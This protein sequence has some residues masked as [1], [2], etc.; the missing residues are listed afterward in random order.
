MSMDTKEAVGLAGG[1]EYV[2]REEQ[3]RTPPRGV[4][5][6]LLEIGPGLILAG[7]IVGTGEL[8][9]TT[10]VGAKVGF[11]LL[12]LVIVSCFIKVFVQAELGR[13]AIS[14]GKTTMQG[15]GELPRVGGVVAWVWLVMMLCTQLQLAAV[16]GGVGQA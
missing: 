9:A 16:V 13:F 5:R 8:I 3:V 11:V 1:D 2:L 6:A 12:W 7:S 14:S 4:G 15:F 10:H